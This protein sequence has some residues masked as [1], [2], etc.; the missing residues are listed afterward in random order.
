[1]TADGSA[2]F[3]REVEPSS[4][5]PVEAQVLCANIYTFYYQ[6]LPSLHSKKCVILTF[7]CNFISIC[8]LSTSTHFLRALYFFHPFLIY[9]ADF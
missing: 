5:H 4:Y 9:M 3:L 1:V 7:Q 2:L 6:I 8:L